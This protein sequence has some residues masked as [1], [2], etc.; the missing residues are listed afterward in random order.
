[1]KL[2]A[3]LF[4]TFIIIPFIIIGSISFWVLYY[5]LLIGLAIQ[6]F[7]TKLFRRKKNLSKRNVW[8]RVIKVVQWNSSQ[9]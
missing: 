1:M 8:Q 4:L 6:T 2:L 5:V 9:R 7:Y 3:E